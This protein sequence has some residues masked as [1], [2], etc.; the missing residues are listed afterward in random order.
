M[1]RESETE[2]VSGETGAENNFRFRMHLFP[3]PRTR[4]RA[5]QPER[6]LA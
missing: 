3:L 5:P 1:G 6:T 4:K 2:T